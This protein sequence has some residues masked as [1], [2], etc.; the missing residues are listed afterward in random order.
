MDTMKLNHSILSAS[1]IGNRNRMRHRTQAALHPV[2]PMDTKTSERLSLTEVVQRLATEEGLTVST[3][4]VRNLA[5]GFRLQ[6]RWYPAYLQEGEHFTRERE[7]RAGSKGRMYT[8]NELYLTE[9]G[10]QRLLHYYSDRSI[11][12]KSISDEGRILPLIASMESGALSTPPRLLAADEEPITPDGDMME[13]LVL[14]T[15]KITL[16]RLCQIRNGYQNVNGWRPPVLQEGEHYYGLKQT[17]QAE[18][19][20]PYTRIVYYYTPKGIAAL[21]EYFAALRA[22]GRPTRRSKKY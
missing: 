22:V 20:R 21:K 18:G 7:R 3:R 14:D 5:E 19:Q 4:R 8:A 15:F 11:R 17:R 1:Q 2:M 12:V 10:Y 13:E 6:G 16:G 9:A